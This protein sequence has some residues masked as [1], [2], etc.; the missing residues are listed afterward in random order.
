MIPF[1]SVVMAHVPLDQ[2]TTDGPRS[3]LQYA[4]GT[5][6]GHLGGL[7]LFNSDTKRVVIRRTYTILGPDPQPY[8][9]PEYD[10]SAEGD[11]T[12]QSVSV[13]T[14]EAS[15]DVNEQKF[16]IGTIHQNPDNMEYYKDVGVV[17]ET[18][19][20]TEGPLAINLHSVT[21]DRVLDYL[22]NTPDLGLVLVGHGG[23]TV[24]YFRRIIWHSCS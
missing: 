12:E 23:A 20:E 10:I 18:Y 19:E 21:L 3:I 15:G 5:S 9:M 14:I 4:V 1:G 16:L 17:E 22:V 7:R 6:L 24:C 8:S 13:D 11:V 2:Q